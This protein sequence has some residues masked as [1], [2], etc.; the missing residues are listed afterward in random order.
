MN[1]KNKVKTMTIAA[2][3]SAL[4]ILIPM[5]APSFPIEPAS[6]TLASHVPIFIAMFISLPVAIFVAIITA[7][8]FLVRLPLVVFLRALS[9]IIFVII[10]AYVLSK[11][12]KLLN[13]KVSAFIFAFVISLIH[14]V[15]EVIVVTWFYSWGGVSEAYYEN[16][17]FI[18]V[19]LLVG[20]GT[21]IHSILD[22]TI[23]VLVWKP[24]QNIISIPVN[25][26]FTKPEPS[27]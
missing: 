10:G 15:C 8:G 1:S 11:N 25:V 3:V 17:Y 27:K 24:I 21:L 14:A 16:G 5:Y 12:K 20:L 22:F 9:H 4:G 13:N 26:R 23:A 19:V 18:S 6:F 7:L 2:L